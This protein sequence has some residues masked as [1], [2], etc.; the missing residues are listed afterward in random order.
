M[1]VGDKFLVTSRESEYAL[2]VSSGH[3]PQPLSVTA[4]RKI[5]MSSTSQPQV[6]QLLQSINMMTCYILHFYLPFKYYIYGV[7]WLTLNYNV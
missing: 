7:M 2:P 6:V 1:K 4:Q 5:P 3:V